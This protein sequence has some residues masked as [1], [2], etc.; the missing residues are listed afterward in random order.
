MGKFLEW[1]DNFKEKLWEDDKTKVE[2]A[3]GIYVKTEE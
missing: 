2:I 3:E 1:Y